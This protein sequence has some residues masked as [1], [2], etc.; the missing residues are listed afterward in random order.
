V[1]GFWYTDPATWNGAATRIAGIR[2]RAHVVVAGTIRTAGTVTVGSSPAW[3]CTLADGTGEIELL[4][5]GR[6]RM[7]GLQPGRRCGVTGTAVPVTARWRPSGP[8]GCAD[9]HG[10]ESGGATPDGARLV[11]W[12]PRYQLAATEEDSDGQPDTDRR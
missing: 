8:Y 12:N 11:I 2:P 5:L 10:A 4:F 7:A 9:G 1:N 3:R 6:A